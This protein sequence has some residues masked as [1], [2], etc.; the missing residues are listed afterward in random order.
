MKSFVCLILLHCLLYTHA[1]SSDQLDVSVDVV[2]YK[3]N[4]THACWAVNT[5]DSC[6]TCCNSTFYNVNF[7]LKKNKAVFVENVTTPNGVSVSYNLSSNMLTVLKVKTGKKFCVVTGNDTSFKQTSN[8]TMETS[9]IEQTCCSVK[10]VFSVATPEPTQVPTQEPEPTQTPTTQPQPTITQKPTVP[11]KQTGF[12]WCACEKRSNAL[13]F[14]PFPSKNILE[15]CYKMSATSCKGHCCV[16]DIAKLDFEYPRPCR[17]SVSKFTINNQVKAVI[18][19][20]QPQGISMKVTNLK[21]AGSKA[22]NT[23]VCIQHKNNCKPV[24]YA[25]FEDVRIKNNCCIV[26]AF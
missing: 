20:Q 19:Q 4:R 26:N 14:K 7:Y 13:V 17:Y 22:N 2:N 18:W 5:T 1:C 16:F 24:K 12:P 10:S 15:T 11:P 23:I 21:I 6:Q 3:L 8:G 25:V 9:N